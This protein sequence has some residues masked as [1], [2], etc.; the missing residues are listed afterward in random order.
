VNLKKIYLDCEY[1]NL[2]KQ[3]A[4]LCIKIINNYEYYV[5]SF[6]YDNF[7]INVNGN[8]LIVEKSNNSLDREIDILVIINFE[9][10]NQNLK[11][12]LYNK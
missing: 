12:L 8:E 2:T 5:D 9:K 3:K 6:V 1:F 7:F 11:I 10:I 4:I